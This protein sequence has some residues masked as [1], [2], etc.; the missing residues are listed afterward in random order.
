VVVLLM[1]GAWSLFSTF[2]QTMVP[3]RA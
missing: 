1:G 3:G 2:R